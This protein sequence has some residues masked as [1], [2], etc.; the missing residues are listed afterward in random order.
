[1]RGSGAPGR[2][3]EHR[4][5][6]YKHGAEEAM[7]SQKKWLIVAIVGAAL[8]LVAVGAVV[9]GLVVWHVVMPVD[10]SLPVYT[11]QQTDS[12]H[13]W[14]RRSTVTCGSAVY[15]NDYEEAS[16]LLVYPEPIKAIGRAPFGNAL[17]CAIDGQKPTDYIA[18]DCGSEMPAYEVFR[19]VKSPVFDW[20]KAKFQAMEFAAN[21]SGVSSDSASG[22][23]GR[24]EHKRTTDPA[25]IADVVRTL[26]A[27]T[28]MTAELP[29]SMT[30]SNLSSVHLFSDELPGL[31]FCPE[32]YRDAAGP[33]Y[34]AES[35]AAEFTNRTVKFHAR[36]IPVSPLFT[37]WVQTP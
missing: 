22:M 21:N 16:L 18:V 32:V 31:K 30:S 6:G 4:R 34:L 2:S 17:I 12:T 9:I 33:V 19:N 1:V 37:Q 5:L 7:M 13:L 3:T 25:L 28:P 27:G 24:A 26:S 35:M 29:V 15:V 11:H 20:R 8:C 36:W 14:Y 10:R 23:I